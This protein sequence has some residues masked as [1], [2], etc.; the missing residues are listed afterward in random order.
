VDAALEEPVGEELQRIR[1]IDRDAAVV[2][3]NPLPRAILRRITNL[4]RRNGLTKQEGETAK[5][6][7]ALDPDIVELG[8]GGRVAGVV[9]HVPQVAV[10][11]GLFVPVA[12]GEVVLGKLE[13]NGEEDEELVDDVVMDVAG[14]MLNLG[15]VLGD[16]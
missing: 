16:Y 5:V 3:T 8:V 7:V 2:R 14:E 1:H 9:L 12:L 10:R 6:G 15:A 11:G 13:D 4:Q